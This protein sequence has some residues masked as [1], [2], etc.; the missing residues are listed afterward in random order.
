[1]KLSSSFV[2]EIRNLIRSARATVARGVD[3]VQV[4]TNYEIGRRIVEQE[5]KGRSRAAYG[6]EVVKALADRLTSE[7]G[8]GFSQTNLKLMRLFYL[9]SQQRIGQT[10]SDQFA[11]DGKCQSLSDHSS[12]MQTKTSKKTTVGGRSSRTFTLSWSHYVFL[13]G[14]KNP[15]R[16]FYGIE[17]GY[18]QVKN[19]E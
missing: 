6:E 2:E 8:K 17:A 18:V 9:Q 1:M 10:L 15:E 4:H 14:V 5:Q 13:L 11:V 19:H 7:F 3:L 16:S 12:I